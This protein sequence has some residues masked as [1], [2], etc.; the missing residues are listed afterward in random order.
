VNPG[1][2]IAIVV[3]AAVVLVGAFFLLRGSD[4]EPAQTDA[5]TKTSTGTGGTEAP[6]ATATTPAQSQGQ[7]QTQTQERPPEPR[8]E[9][10]RIS[11]GRPASGNARTLE[12]D[13]GQTVRLRFASNTA[14][15]IHIHGYDKTA[16]V[17]AGGT[18]RVQ[19]KA[20]AEGIF[21]IEEHHSGALLAR[22]E[23]RP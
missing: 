10:I 1:Q 9:T 3:V 12:F 2:R 22:L 16:A 5:V 18:A 4:D 21:E 11:D 8:V 19:F 15:E 14:A 23:V 7:T 13:S 17:P 20:D 6:S